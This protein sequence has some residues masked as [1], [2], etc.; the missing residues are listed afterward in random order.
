MDRTIREQEVG[1]NGVFAG[2]IVEITTGWTVV[3]TGMDQY[4]IT[5]TLAQF[6]WYCILIKL[7]L[8]AITAADCAH[9]G[10]LDICKSPFFN[11]DRITRPICNIR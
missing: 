5:R 9:P 1:T 2:S 11:E 4:Q 6:P 3:R 10:A 7:P 8:V